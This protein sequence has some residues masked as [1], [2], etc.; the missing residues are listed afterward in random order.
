MKF[1]FICSLLIFLLLINSCKKT[2]KSEEKV[3][4]NTITFINK[5]DENITIKDNSGT[6]V[7]TEFILFA[8]STKE[9]TYDCTNLQWCQLEWVYSFPSVNIFYDGICICQEE[10]ISNEQYV[11]GYCPNVNA[12]PEESCV[13]CNNPNACD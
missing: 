9:L 7:F 3:Q 2:T 8:Y 11:F 6:G 13:T 12:P 1:R 5:T 4:T 10:M